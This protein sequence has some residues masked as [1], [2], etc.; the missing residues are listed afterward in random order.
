MQHELSRRIRP[1]TKMSLLMR[2]SRSIQHVIPALRGS[3]PPQHRRLPGDEHVPQQQA[4][5]VASRCATCTLSTNASRMQYACSAGMSSWSCGR[6][7]RCPCGWGRLFRAPHCRRATAHTAGGAIS[8]C[9]R[10]SFYLNAHRTFYDS[11]SLS[12]GWPRL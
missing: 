7:T 2:S 4:R 6:S 8:C 5:G 12:L 1:P 3:A 11:L 10:F 9:A